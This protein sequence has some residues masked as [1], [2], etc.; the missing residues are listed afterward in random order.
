LLPGDLTCLVAAHV[1][2]SEEAEREN[3]L[4]PMAEK[5]T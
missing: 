4:N 5:G 1:N 2:C 3:D